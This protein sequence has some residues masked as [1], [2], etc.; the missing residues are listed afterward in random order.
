MYSRMK[1]LW[2]LLLSCVMLGACDK[3]P[4]EEPNPPPSDNFAKGADIGWLS[5]M[6]SK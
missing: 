1:I 5:E 3:K 6:E 2:V 4:G